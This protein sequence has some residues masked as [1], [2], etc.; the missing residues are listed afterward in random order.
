[1]P[2]SGLQESAGLV[3]ESLCETEQE[4]VPGALDTHLVDTANLRTMIIRA[5]VIMRTSKGALLLL[6]CAVNP[7]LIQD[8]HPISPVLSLVQ[9]VRFAEDIDFKFPIKRACAS[10]LK[11]FC[12][13]IP[14]GE[15]T[16][17]SPSLW[18]QTGVRFPF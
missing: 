13:N 7:A 3:L 10:E 4:R 17:E 9:L 16:T 11:K 8:S 14:Q 2:A 12:K 1:M 5:C 15:S 18:K 6:P